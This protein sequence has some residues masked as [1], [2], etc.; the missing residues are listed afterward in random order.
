MK[1]IVDEYNPGWNNLYKTES[2]KIAEILG[3]Q[4]VAIHHI[5]S[6]SVKG[7][8]A[9]PVIDIMPV[10]KNITPVDGFNKEFEALGYECMGEYGIAGRRFFRRGGEVR[11][12]HVHIFQESNQK[13]ILRHLAV[14][15]YLREFPEIAKAY[16]ELK[17]TLARQFPEDIESYCDGKNSFVKALEQAALEWYSKK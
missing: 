17:K 6:T 4:L 15:N 11:T 9:K 14:R 2:G 5:G 12:H 8:H 10:V 13:D 16:G 7:L 3:S 1:V